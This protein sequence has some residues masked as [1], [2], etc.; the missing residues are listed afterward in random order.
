MVFRVF[1][2]LVNFLFTF[3]LFACRIL[4]ILSLSGTIQLKSDKLTLKFVTMDVFKKK[5]LRSNFWQ[6]KNSGVY[7]PVLIVRKWTRNS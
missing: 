6:K 4:F 7:A 1:K 2:F 5:I 3:K